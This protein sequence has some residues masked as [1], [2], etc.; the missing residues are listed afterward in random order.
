MW[1]Q[2]MIALITIPVIDY[3]LS[4][5]RCFV[6]LRLGKYVSSVPTHYAAA[7]LEMRNSDLWHAS[8]FHPGERLHQLCFF[9]TSFC[10]PAKCPYGTDRLTDGQDP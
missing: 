1:I 8:N 2:I 9:S 10:F 5:R 4:Q 6:R 3:F 7:R